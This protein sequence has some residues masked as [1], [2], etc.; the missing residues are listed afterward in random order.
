L[1]KPYSPRRAWAGGHP[2]A[3]KAEFVAKHLRTAKGR[4]LQRNEFFCSL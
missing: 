3:A 2:S 1:K 4:T